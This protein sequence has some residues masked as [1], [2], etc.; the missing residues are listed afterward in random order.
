M[1]LVRLIARVDLHELTDYVAS[2]PTWRLL[3]A[4]AVTLMNFAQLTLYDRI[5]LAYIGRNFPRVR[6]AMVSFIATAFAHNVGPSLA[7]GGSVRYRFYSDWGLSLSEV[8]IVVTLGM[9]TFWAGFAAIAGPTLV[10]I[11]A[12]SASR[13]SLPRDALRVVGSVLLVLEAGYW[14]FCSMGP[15]EIRIRR[16]SFKVPSPKLAAAQCLVGAADWFAMTLVLFLLLPEGA[17]SFPSLLGIFILV[18]ITAM[19]SQLPGGLGVFESLMVAALAPMLSVGTVVA[20]LL[21]YRVIYL[22]MPLVIATIGLVGTE[23]WNL[24]R[25]K[26][27]PSQPTN[28]MSDH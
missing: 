10:A 3:G 8:S 27:R 7:T 5:G 23:W 11:D 15:R 6:V 22:V 16:W 21:L 9:V 4:V 20:A 2:I 28:G 14:A 19:I 24:R 12:A 26:S 25:F 1:L 13:L 18:Q 17:V